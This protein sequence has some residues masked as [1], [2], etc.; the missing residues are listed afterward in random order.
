VWAGAVAIF[1]LVT[2]S[3]QFND[4]FSTATLPQKEKNNWEDLQRGGVN[5]TGFICTWAS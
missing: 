4:A 1:F 3:L 5:I 2:S